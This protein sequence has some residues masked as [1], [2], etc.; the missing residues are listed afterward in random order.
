I[1]AVA[2]LWKG[3]LYDSEVCTQLETMV[4]DW[5]AHEV[6]A[7]RPVAAIEGLSTHFRSR[8]L[9]DWGQQLLEMAQG[10]LQRMQCRDAEGHDESQHL[11]PLAALLEARQTPADRLLQRLG[12]AMPTRRAIIDA[13]AI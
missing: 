4:A 6:E 8:S 7:L 1:P 11:A 10:A 12:P 13:T 5:P 3:L 2:A 9:G